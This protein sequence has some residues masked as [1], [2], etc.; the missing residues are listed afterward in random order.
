MDGLANKKKIQIAI[1][2]MQGGSAQGWA[3]EY[4]RKNKTA[5]AA[6]TVTWETFTTALDTQFKDEDLEVT[7]NAHEETV[8]LV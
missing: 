2:Y 7:T 1:S 6:G 4:M 5:L 3:Q 8:I